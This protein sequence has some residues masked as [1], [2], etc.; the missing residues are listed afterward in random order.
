MARDRC[1]LCDRII[2]DGDDV[3]RPP[4]LGVS[5]H[6]TCYL[7]ETGLDDID[8][9]RRTEPPHPHVRRAPDPPGW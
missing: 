2:F 6:R 9:P 4:L 5:V 1:I 7:R 3:T 8:V